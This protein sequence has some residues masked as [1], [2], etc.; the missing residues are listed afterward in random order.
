[1]SERKNKKCIFK[2]SRFVQKNKEEYETEGV[3]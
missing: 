2:E 3:K 1:M